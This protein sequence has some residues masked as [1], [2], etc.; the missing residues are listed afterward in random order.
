MLQEITAKNNFNLPQLLGDNLVL[1]WATPA[2]TEA[3]VD[4][5]GRTFSHTD[6]PDEP[7]AFWTHDMM[8][9]DHPTVNAG[10]FTVVVDEANNG[11]IVSS[12]NLISQTWAYEDVQFGAG[13]PEVVSTL[14]EYRRRGLVRLQLEAVH[15]KSAARGELMQAITGI[16]WYYRQFGYEMALA[17]HGDRRLYWPNVTKLEKEQAEIYRLRRATV[18]DIPVRSRLYDIFCSYSL[19]SRVRNE[20]EWQYELTIPHEKSL[21][22]RRFFMLEKV[23]NSEPIGYAE[24]GYW[25]DLTPVR[26]L[27]IFPGN[28]W[29]DVGEF[30]TR[31]LKALVAERNQQEKRETPLEG[32][33]FGLGLCHPIYEALGNQLEK[34]RQPYA[35]YIRIP[36]LQAF[37]QRIAPVLERRL[38]E[39]VMEGYSGSLRLNFYRSHLA[40]TFE[41]GKLKELGTYKKVKIQD[42]DASFPD[43]V[44]YQ[45][46]L[47]YRSFEE[48]HYA[49]PDCFSRSERTAV[50]LDVLF[51]KKPSHV[52]GLE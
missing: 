29:R 6:Q 36:N 12:L 48:L 30:L 18:E 8:R 40:L 9:G 25:P 20:I 42:G 21:A 51:P 43:L 22:Y 31:A 2:D 45:L 32:A 7:I 44:F 4:F 26:E 11:K 1:R 34:Q 23:A 52:I 27:A 49:F 24:I 16:P 10:D 50:L 47:G 35:W 28:S 37:I 13:R 19:V 46:L 15:A 39:S 38:Q 41:Q 33:S 17:L 3:L 5:N 14:P